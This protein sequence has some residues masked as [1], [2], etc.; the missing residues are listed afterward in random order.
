MVL[1]KYEYSVVEPGTG[2]YAEYLALRHSVFCE[3]LGRI[4]HAASPLKATIT[5]CTVSTCCA[6]LKSRALPLAARV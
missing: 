5:M 2:A 3:E 1:E 4:V 6:V